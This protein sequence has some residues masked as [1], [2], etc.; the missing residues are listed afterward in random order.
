[1]H[2]ILAFKGQI[3]LATFFGL[4]VKERCCLICFFCPCYTIITNLHDA[5][6]THR[7]RFWPVSPCTKKKFSATSCADSLVH[8]RFFFY[9]GFWR[10]VKSHRKAEKRVFPFS[11]LRSLW[12]L[13]VGIRC[14][15][16][17]LKSAWARGSCMEMLPVLLGLKSQM[18][19]FESM[20]SAILEYGNLAKVNA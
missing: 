19:I 16:K 12:S 2:E 4:F 11:A 10:S 13:P 6:S 20:S 18:A 5:K 15:I 1:M 8:R 17:N 9:A 7:F 3:I 14:R